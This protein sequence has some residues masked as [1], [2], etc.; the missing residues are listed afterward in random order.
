MMSGGFYRLKTRVF[1]F[2]LP[3]GRKFGKEIELL[4]YNF[5]RSLTFFKNSVCKAFHLQFK[6][7]FAQFVLVWFH[8]FQSFHIELDGDIGFDG[9]QE[10]THL[11]V[12]HMFFHFLAKLAFDFWRAGQQLIDAA[13]FINEFGG[14][15]LTNSWTAR[16]V[17]GRV[18][19]QGQ[20]VNDGHGGGDIV[21]LAYLF[22]AQCFIATSVS[23]T[24]DENIVANQLSV[25]LIGCEHI[26][27]YTDGTCF[28][29]YGSDDVISLEAIHLQDGNAIC[30]QQIF[31][32]GNGFADILWR[33][34]ALGFIGR[35]GFAAERGAMRVEGHT[36]VGWL[37]F[38][39]HLVEGVQ[40]AHYGTCVQAFRVDSGIFDERIIAAI[41][42]RISV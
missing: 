12:L 20:Q 41:N 16:E 40:K 33:F 4:I 22:G 7:Q 15:F 25:V 23:G 13:K 6:Q 29:C 26:G 37:L 9:C 17:V 28:S 38:G 10:V 1:W 42:E 24:I 11:D 18:A 36:D 30:F 2:F 3:V 32:D 31:D 39:E 19:H 35:K 21:F 5:L 14:C 8:E 27:F 34:F